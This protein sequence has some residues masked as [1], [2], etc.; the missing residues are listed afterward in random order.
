M[1]ITIPTNEGWSFES[2][3]GTAAFV[4]APFENWSVSNF[5]ASGDFDLVISTP[6][7]TLSKVTVPLPGGIWLFGTAGVGLLIRLRRKGQAR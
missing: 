2:V 1:L 6:G 5:L 7:V 3:F 4:C